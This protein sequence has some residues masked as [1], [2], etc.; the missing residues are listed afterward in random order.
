MKKILSLFA[1][2]VLSVNSYAS[3]GMHLQSAN[4]DLSDTDSLQ[5]GAALF[6]NYCLSCHSAKFMRYN[7]MGADLGLSDEQVKANLM[8]AG[9]KIGET[10]TVAMRPEDAEN[11]FGV[12]PPDLSVI[13]RA[14]GSDW[15]Y[16]YMLSFYQDDSRPW[17]VNN[18]VF[19]DV[20]MP[21]VFLERQ[22]A[23]KPVYEAEI[24]SDGKEHQMIKHLEALE[25]EKAEA[26]KQD[27]Q[28]LVNFLAYMGEPAKMVRYDLGKKVL[29]F[30]LLLFVV[31]YL[32]KKE[33]WRDV[34]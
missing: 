30:L 6:V 18:L 1:G 24:G 19:K 20:G 2:L 11:W 21:H 25:P 34:K 27:V 29:V 10:M 7:R 32:L 13:D 28:D 3:G 14:R 31:S 5:R 23:Q 16:T 33:Y 17:G 15:V 22:G 12:I 26:Y 4:V 8:F 9:E